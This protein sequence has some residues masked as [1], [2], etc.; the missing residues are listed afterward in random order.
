MKTETTKER[1]QG[2][3]LKRL[4]GLVR[5]AVSQF[6]KNLLPALELTDA[7]NSRITEMLTE[8]IGCGYRPSDAMEAVVE[9]LFA[10]HEE[11]MVQAARDDCNQA[12][13]AARRSL[14][15]A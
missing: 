3:D 8:N 12:M 1:L 9:L 5:D 14:P 10:L 11:S 13:E 4:V 2:V 7:D 15:N 6:G